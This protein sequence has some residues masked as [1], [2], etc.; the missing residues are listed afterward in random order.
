[1]I[2]LVV[3]EDQG[4]V[5]GA[6]SSLLNL[7]SDIEVVGQARD[8]V[9]ALDMVRDLDPDVLMTDI[10]MPGLSGLEVVDAMRRERR[11]TQVLVVTTFA[12]PGYLRRALQA[13][14][15]GY[16]LKDTPS[17]DLAGAVRRI[18]AGERVVTPDLAATAWE[19]ADP[20]ND[21]EREVLR[22]AEKGLSAKQMALVI[23]LSAG[24]V[25]NY[26]H[27]ASQKVG[28]TGKYEAAVIARQ[29]GWL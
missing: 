21:R 17:A 2:R 10:E 15:R 5:L 8:G 19:A 6:L 12:R 25:R 20:L 23:G 11:R 7:E 9:Q 3:A 24:T 14:V 27:E 29:K 16:L 13:G 26:L 22:F 28:A 18:V 1:M 4:L